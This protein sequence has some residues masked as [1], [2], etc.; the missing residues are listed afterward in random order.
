MWSQCWPLHHH[1]NYINSGQTDHVSRKTAPIFGRHLSLCQCQ[2]K[3]TPPTIV[4]PSVLI[5]SECRDEKHAPALVVFSQLVSSSLCPLDSDEDAHW[6]S[7]SPIICA[8]HS[9]SQCQRWFGH[10]SVLCYSTLSQ[11]QIELCIRLWSWYICE[12]MIPSSL[13]RGCS[14]VRLSSL[15]CW[16]FSLTNVSRDADQMFLRIIFIDNTASSRRW[17]YNPVEGKPLSLALRYPLRDD[18]LTLSDDLDWVKEESSTGVS[19]ISFWV[20]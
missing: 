18:F 9:L 14:F 12:N 4:L 6:P 20:M 1:G 2:S 16:H 11:C 17:F 10:Q 3:C 7:S 15:L 8:D 5:V 13:F 19:F